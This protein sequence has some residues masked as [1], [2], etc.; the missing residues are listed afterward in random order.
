MK[1][2]MLKFPYQ[3]KSS[4]EQTGTLLGHMEA[5]VRSDLSPELVVSRSNAWVETLLFKMKTP[6]TLVVLQYRPPDCSNNMFE[7]ALRV[8]KEVIEESTNGDS[9]TRNILDFEDYNFPCIKWPLRRIY[10]NKNTERINKAGDKEQ[11]EMCLN[12]QNEYFMVNVVQTATT[13]AKILDL[14]S[15]NNQDLN[16]CYKVT[17]N[18]KLSNH[19]TVEVRL[20]IPFNKEGKEEKVKKPY[21]TKIFEYDTSNASEEQLKR[22]DQFDEDCLDDM[23][24]EEQLDIFLGVME[25]AVEMSI[26]RKKIF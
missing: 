18:K 2:L 6:D 1:Y 7:D 24:P 10:V 3:S 21:T 26:P 22:M 4:C 25:E 20:N 13:G 11:A 14:I 17:V 8:S 9:R 19:N 16:M 12:F 23:N 5:W 15:T